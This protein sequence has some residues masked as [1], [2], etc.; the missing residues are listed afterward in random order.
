MRFEYYL[1]LLKN[2]KV[3]LG[4]S[5][6]GIMEA[7][8]YGIPTINIGDRQKNRS[9]LKTIEHCEFH[10]KKILGLVNKMFLKTRRHKLKSE[11]GKGKSFE[12][13]YKIL[14]SKN[15]WEIDTQKH[16]QDMK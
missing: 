5:S 1:V 3:I 12:I 16:F 10:E 8:Y 14:R 11:F 2:S 7:P 6:S 13:F 4:N 9:Q 15:I